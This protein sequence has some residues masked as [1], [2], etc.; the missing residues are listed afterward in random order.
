M[1][2]G[3]RSM[4]TVTVLS[5]ILISTGLGKRRGT[6]GVLVQANISGWVDVSCLVQEI[7]EMIARKGGEEKT[8][9]FCSG[10]NKVLEDKACLQ[11][12]GFECWR[13]VAGWV[14][15]TQEP[16]F[17]R[18]LAMHGVL[19][20]QLAQQEVLVLPLHRNQRTVLVRNQVLALPRVVSSPE[21]PTYKDNSKTVMSALVLAPW[22]TSRAAPADMGAVHAPP[23]F[24]L[25]RSED[26][27]TAHVEALRDLFG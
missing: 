12:V 10:K 16:P 7:K 19:L 15:L 6:V 20:H 18:R 25:R 2:V 21:L 1:E 17:A 24:I 27:M 22:A 11:E 9:C 13:S 3:C 8:V 5:L 4:Q 23:T 14:C 26:G